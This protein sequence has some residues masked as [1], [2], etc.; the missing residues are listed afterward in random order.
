[1][2]AFSTLFALSVVRDLLW[3][4]AAQAGTLPTDEARRQALLQTV[5]V[6]LLGVSSALTAFG[7]FEARRLARV[8]DVR[9]PIVDLPAAL[10]SIVRDF[11]SN[12]P[13]IRLA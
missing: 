10:V 7:V 8:V 11:A 12:L 13:R 5:N 3:L 6:S 9:I 4:F 1:M 2:G